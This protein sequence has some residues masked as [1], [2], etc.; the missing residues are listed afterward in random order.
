MAVGNIP[1]NRLAD[2]YFHDLNVIKLSPENKSNT[3]PHNLSKPPLD[4]SKINTDTLDL[5]I[6]ALEKLAAEQAAYYREPVELVTYPTSYG[7]F[8]EGGDY[9]TSV[10]VNFPHTSFDFGSDVSVDDFVQK[11]I[12]NQDYVNQFNTILKNS[13]GD[14]KSGDAVFI[15]ALNKYAELKNSISAS[16]SPYAETQIKQLENSLEWSVG[17]SLNQFAWDMTSINLVF[18]KANSAKNIEDIKIRGTMLDGGKGDDLFTVDNAFYKTATN[19]VFSA[20][21]LIEKGIDYINDNQ[22]DPKNS[23]DASKL[24][25]AMNNGTDDA[26]SSNLSLSTLAGVI[27]TFRGFITAPDQVVMS[28]AGNLASNAPSSDIGAVYLSIKKRVELML[29]ANGKSMSLL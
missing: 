13:N 22:Y 25:A 28:K 10:P 2:N 11:G 8:N 12:I 9:S 1:S 29:S 16:N 6:E 3:Q 21:K 4:L 24:L 7:R 19:I 27:S 5:S 14:L 26:D 23:A 18:Y 20:A 15:A 17:T